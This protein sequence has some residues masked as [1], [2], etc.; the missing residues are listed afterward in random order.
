MIYFLSKLSYEIHQKTWLHAEE[1]N[2]Y[3]NLDIIV[4]NGAV[5]TLS[6][7]SR[8][9]LLIKAMSKQKISLIYM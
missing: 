8:T 5:N 4:H 9:K 3:I 6:V 2:I 7:L 1:F